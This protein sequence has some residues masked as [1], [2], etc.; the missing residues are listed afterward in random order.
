MRQAIYYE[1][2]IRQLPIITYNSLVIHGLPPCVASYAT[3]SDKVCNWG[4]SIKGRYGNLRRRVSRTHGSQIIHVSKTG[5]ERVPRWWIGG[6]TVY[7]HCGLVEIRGNPNTIREPNDKL[8]FGENASLMGLGL[9]SEIRFFCCCR[10][11]LRE[12]RV[13]KCIQGRC[14]HGSKVRRSVREV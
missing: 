2:V 3:R 10:F 5:T 9:H 14:K 4:T 11:G 13:I 1:R 6:P 8:L 12:V 7:G